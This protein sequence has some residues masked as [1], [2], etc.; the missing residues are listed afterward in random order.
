MHLSGS[1]EPI[2]IGPLCDVNAYSRLRPLD[3][4]GLGSQNTYL[5]TSCPGETLQAV[6]DMT[7]G[8]QSDWFVPSAAEMQLD[9][10]NSEVI[11]LPVGKN[12]SYWSPTKGSAGSTA[13][14]FRT[15]INYWKTH[16]GTSS[17]GCKAVLMRNF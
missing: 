15:D 2:G 11:G 4:I 17:T 7:A 6:K 8:G 13:R 5:A 14:T 1:R 3:G 9:Y 16:Y 12:F 10:D